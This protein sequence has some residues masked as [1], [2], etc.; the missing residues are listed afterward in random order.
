MAFLWLTYRKNKHNLSYMSNKFYVT[1][2]IYYVNDKPHIGSTYTT[3]IADVLARA[4][5]LRGDKTL[6]LTG[7]DENSQKNLEASIKAGFSD[8]PSYLD[9][10]ALVWQSTWKTLGLTF[11]DFIRTTEDRHHKGVE[12]F[13]RAVQ[14]SG[15]IYK[16]EYEREYCVGCEAFKTAHDLVD[17]HCPLHPNKELE[18]VKEENYFFRASAY[19]DELLK[20]YHEHPEFI[21]PKSRM[22]EIRSYVKDAFEDF[23]ISRESGQLS[24]GIPVPDDDSQ[25]IYVWF[26]A[27]LNYMTAVGYG[28]DDKLFKKWWPADVH[29]VGKDIIKFHCAL[30]PAMIMSAAKSDP[31]LLDEKGAILLPKSVHVNGFFTVDGQK[32]SKSLGNAIDP[33]DLIKEY[34]FDVIRYFILRE[35]PYGED[36]DFSKT[37]LAER[38]NSDLANTLGN[39]VNRAVAMSRKYFNGRV[40]NVKPEEAKIALPD[41][42]WGGAECLEIL[43]QTVDRYLDSSRADLVLESIWSSN[44]CSLNS[45]NRYVEQTKP[46]KL[47]KDDP[48]KAALVLY[49]LLEA[50]R[51]FAWMISP[52]M[53]DI[54]RKIIL[55]L[56]QDHK[57]EEQK[58]AKD[59]RQWGGLV[60]DSELPEP[61]ILF[62]RLTE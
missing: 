52:M 33:L 17:G 24:C 5:R 30:W 28:T 38:Y 25:R 58:T 18:K 60:P 21:E 9:S 55:Q 15:D 61:A 40:P 46:F 45:A 11:D 7:T 19:K 26:D 59:L 47:I 22:N 1:T 35:I 29:L 54:A 37:R 6:F 8:M 53:P 14:Q 42:E 51:H 3:V 20:L 50:C 12:R 4:H 44:D 43:W 34:P 62:P 56:G 2:P 23:S 13:W 48:E 41:T 32:I 49:A 27:L 10:M 31:A 39:L 57:K 16:A 36:G